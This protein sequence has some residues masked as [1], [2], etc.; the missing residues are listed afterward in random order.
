M[1]GFY[2][3]YDGDTAFTSWTP[4]NFTGNGSTVAFT[5]GSNPDSENNTQVY[6]AGVYQQ[7]DGYSVSGTVL[8]FSVAPPNLSTIEVMVNTAMALGATSSD[9]VSYTPAGTGA[10]ATTVQ[11]KL[12]ES[13]SVKDFGAT[14]DGTTD[15]SA[16]INLAATHCRSTGSALTA[17]AGLTFYITQAVDLTDIDYIDFAGN[18]KA[19]T[20]IAAIP[21]VVGG[22]SAT[23]SQHWKFNNV[24]DDGYNTVSAAALSRP[25][26]RIY[27]SKCAKIEIAACQYVQLYADST[28]TGRTSNAYNT[29]NLQI[30]YRFEITGLNSGW[31][32]ENSIFQG[33]IK[34]L[35]IDGTNYGHNHNKFYDSTLEGTDVDVQ[36]LG[37]AYHNFILG[38]RFENSAG[39]TGITFGA[40]TYNNLIEFSWSGVGNP[41]SAYEVAPPVADSGQNNIVRSIFFTGSQKV[42]ICGISSDTGVLSDGSNWTSLSAHTP[43]FQVV[44]AATITPGLK[45]LSATSLDT[46]LATPLIPVSSGDVFGIDLVSAD[47][48]WRRQVYIYDSN[49]K[50]I[51]SE[52]GLGEYIGATGTSFSTTDGKGRYSSTA[53]SSP[54][55]VSNPMSVIRTEVAYIQ[56]ALISY[57]A[58]TWE[59]ASIYIYSNKAGGEVHN[60]GLNYMGSKMPALANVPTQGYVPVG[61]CIYDVSALGVKY[62]SYSHETNLDASIATSGTSVTVLDV[63]SIANGDVVGILLD[64]GTTHWSTVSAL[65]GSSF[66]VSA[67]PSLAADL[68]RVVF[69]RWA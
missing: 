21:V 29:I 37:G 54:A 3:N 55:S 60:L 44:T 33:R 12:R 51:I 58:S 61:T 57:A 63:R 13:V 16:A 46:I 18:I 69:N 26:F 5:L 34:K 14:G 20:A 59:S 31:N 27:G 10:V 48:T 64:D 41:R 38:A 39:S 42:T 25:V 2:E 56:V 52:G 17:P 15:D 19:D 32:N 50:A 6:I 30:V 24:T 4:Y 43:S 8:T 65:V 67:L 36:F 47:S 1:T 11:A 49:K 62:C 7:K 45:I 40:D 53:N 23:N 22:F 68:S 28:V 35:T 9:L 66:T